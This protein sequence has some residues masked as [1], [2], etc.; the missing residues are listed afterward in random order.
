MNKTKIAILIAAVAA[1]SAGIGYWAG[2]RPS[3]APT[4]AASPAAGSSQKSQGKVLYWYDPMVPNQHFD[5][6]GKS[7]FMEMQL[8]PK[9]AEEGV[10]NASIAIDP[11]VTQNLGVRLAKVER[12]SLDQAVSAVAT[13]QF[14]D[15][16]VAVVQTRAAGFVQRV[17]ARAPGD[18]I[19]RGA[20]LAD[21]LVPDWTG[22]QEELLAV[23]GTGDAALLAATRQRLKLLGMPE[24]LIAR[25]ERT[26][27]VSTS[28]TLTAP[29]AG[30]I[31]ELGVR[32]GM[33]L[34]QGMSVAKINGLATVWLEAA[35]PQ[36]QAGAIR[37]GQTAKATLAAF[38]GQAFDGKV[39]AVLPETD[40]NS[41]TLR[42]RIELP[43]KTGRLRP[44][45]FSQVQ[46]T[47]GQRQPVL[48]VPSE[49]VIRTGT[50]SVVITSAGDGHFKPVEVQLG[51]ESGDKTA[52]I[53]GLAEG[54]QVVASG[55]FLIDSE[56]SLRGVLS[57]LVTQP[58]AKP[59]APA[60]DALHQGSGKVEK[61]DGQAITL[62]HGPIAS[63]GWGAMTM[64]FQLASPDLAKGL[65]PG[66]TVQ[67]AFR[68]DGGDFVIKQ[69]HK[70]GGEQ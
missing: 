2:H 41:R 10:D 17:Y 31:Q 59:T 28:T 49:A 13:V 42:V 63:M 61:L 19:A 23:R 51:Q 27:R 69:L 64:T 14:N 32:A 34:A 25:V 11:S 56:A 66:D 53:A 5:K 40:A 58:T 47:S 21:V 16:D 4:A 9:Y 68:Q 57:Q 7:P 35:V 22:A 18:L 39:I 29:I 30:V 44:G 12:G 20:P 50:R 33:T 26:G 37:V 60:A 38:P 15:R 24:E 67:F 6:P 43:N 1:A 54:D 65:K 55:Q 8:V 3:Q 36:A 48:L 45:M 62:S 52:V 46:L 70:A